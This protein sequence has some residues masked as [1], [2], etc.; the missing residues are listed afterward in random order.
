MLRDR[1]AL[2]RLFEDGA[3]LVTGDGRR[4]ARG[5]AQ[6]ADL[7]TAL[8]ERDRTYVADPRRVL[9][10]RDTGL[11]VADRGINVVRRG[12]DVAW[13]FTISLLSF[14]PATTPQEKP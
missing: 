12:S 4:E 6:I 2:A 5:R 13:R 9:Q 11:V 7:A 10:T 3:V 1:A 14:G 8:W